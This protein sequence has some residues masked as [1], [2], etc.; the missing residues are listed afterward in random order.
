MQPGMLL[1]F[2]FFAVC[3]IMPASDGCGCLFRFL[4]EGKKG[5][6]NI[7]FD[8][9]INALHDDAVYRLFYQ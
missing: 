2:Y 8:G 5:R 6:G 4:I 3:L 9:F 7:I 1:F